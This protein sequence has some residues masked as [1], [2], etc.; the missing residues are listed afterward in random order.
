[1]RKKFL[2]VALM[3]LAIAGCNNSDREAM[4]AITRSLERTN[5]W[6]VN[7]KD[8]SYGVLKHK[9]KDRRQRPKA[10]IWFPKA[11]QVEEMSVELLAYLDTLQGKVQLSKASS[12]R[13]DRILEKEGN[14]LYDKLLA[15]CNAIPAVIDTNE[16]ADNPTIVAQLNKDMTYLKKKMVLRFGLVK[17]SAPD[18]LIG[19]RQWQDEHLYELTPFL[20][21]MMLHKLKNDIVSMERPMVEYLN[22]QATSYSCGFY[23]MYSFLT[24]ISSGQVKAGQPIEINAGSASFSVDPDPSITIYD[25]CLAIGPDGTAIYRF[26]AQGKPGKYYIPVNIAYTGPDDKP[27]IVTKQLE[28]IIA[29]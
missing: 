9:L 25:S 11:Q 18:L 10:I 27:I 4:K 17:D 1:M 29:P 20:A 13:I 5:E 6:V 7:R 23:E 21:V 2:L 19:A 12:R 14:R 24:L 28:Y 26:R 3:T 22:N 15:F 8:L 16:F